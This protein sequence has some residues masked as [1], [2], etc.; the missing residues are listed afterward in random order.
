MLASSEPFDC[1][2][3][4]S[5]N[6][7]YQLTFVA[8]SGLLAT[9]DGTI[10]QFAGEQFLVQ[11]YRDREGFAVEYGWYPT[12]P[13]GWLKILSQN[14]FTLETRLSGGDPAIQSIYTGNPGPAEKTYEQ[15]KDFSTSYAFQ[16]EDRLL[17]PLAA[18]VLHQFVRADY[19]VL[20]PCRF[21]TLEYQEMD[22]VSGNSS[23]YKRTYV[24]ELQLM[25]PKRTVPFPKD[26]PKFTIDMTPTKLETEFQTFRE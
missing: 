1:E 25:L 7:P 18:N 12:R 19:I 2:K 16:A 13:H 9:S 15:R 4:K 5:T 10:R 21:T 26:D 11:V 20:G 14:G 6:M 3:L 8:P 23:R 24:P 22:A 17:P